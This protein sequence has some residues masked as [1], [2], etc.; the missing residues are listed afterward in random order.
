MSF[1]KKI[2]KYLLIFLLGVSFTFIAYNGLTQLKRITSL[3][4]YE[5][6]KYENNSGEKIQK[7]FQQLKY[8][9]F[10]LERSG[11]M[12]AKSDLRDNRYYKLLETQKTLRDKYY[13]LSVLDM[14]MDVAFF[15]DNKG[16]NQRES[17]ELDTFLDKYNLKVSDVRGQKKTVIKD[18]KILIFY[19]SADN[20]RGYIFIFNRNAIS[21]IE[22]RRLGEWYLSHDGEDYSFT[23]EGET[24][25]RRKDIFI[26]D[27][28]LNVGFSFEK[29][30]DMPEII[31]RVLLFYIIIPMII[32]IFLCKYLSDKVA[33]KFYYPLRDILSTIEPGDGVRED[34]DHIINYLGEL[35]NQNSKLK[36]EVS[37]MEGAVKEKD[38]KDYMYGSVPKAYFQ[39][40]Y[41]ESI[42]A[43]YRAVLLKFDSDE[44]KEGLFVIKGEL[45]NAIEDATVI[46]I[47]N[48]LYMIFMKKECSKKALKDLMVD[49]YK[50]YEIE[51]TGFYS[52]KTYSIDELYRCFVYFYKY[53]DYKFMLE[54]N[55]IIDEKDVENDKGKKYYYPIEVEQR[56]MNKCLKGNFQGAKV[57]IDEIFN[58]NFL[59]RKIDRKTFETLKIL[60][61]SSLKRL[62]NERVDRYQD[63]FLKIGDPVNLKDYLLKILKECE[64]TLVP[65]EKG[66]IGF[67]TAEKIDAFIE[68]NYSEDISLLDLSEDLGV[69]LQYA[70]NLHKKVKGENFNQYLNRYRIEKSVEILK[71]DDSVKIKDLA[72][73]V[74]YINTNTFINNFKKIKGTS[75]GKYIK[76]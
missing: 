31:L 63:D 55:I 71:N 42:G 59:E 65:K 2:K 68:I 67:I 39:D 30:N 29:K 70:S 54:E 51:G 41:R 58:E 35:K 50:K 46:N 43:N 12:M 11:E 60:L 22:E 10:Q 7:K 33:E 32:M 13:L 44:F 1:L 47:D 72:L 57:I 28:D 74:G 49:L 75:P 36:D 52:D 15:S 14:R 18:G 3:K 38:V 27:K 40:K 69:S 26:Y 21:D 6:S 17:Y 24:L 23:S 48:S 37:Y 73:M 62:G 66:S 53:L 64:E 56:W 5:I 9:L 16:V 61:F 76:K 4:N 19:P 20:S 34:V 45:Q 8:I 25:I